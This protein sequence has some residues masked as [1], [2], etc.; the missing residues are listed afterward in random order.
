MF[1]CSCIGKNLIKK[2]NLENKNV[3][4]N[5]P[6][7][8][9]LLPELTTDVSPP[10]YRAWGSIMAA[11]CTWV[12]TRAWLTQ[13]LLLLF[14]FAVSIWCTSSS[15]AI[16]QPVLSD[17]EYP[18]D[19]NQLPWKFLFG[20][21]F[22]STSLSVACICVLSSSVQYHRRNDF[23]VCYTVYEIIVLGTYTWRRKH[24]GVRHD[25]T[26]Y[27]SRKFRWLLWS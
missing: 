7:N 2:I 24:D 4:I 20:L 25:A 5:H 3:E 9:L 10:Q 18:P 21:S 11:R 8:T 14:L 27:V 22:L 15:A 6:S 26:G 16:L 19:R 17:G 1:S 12:R 23:I 13:L